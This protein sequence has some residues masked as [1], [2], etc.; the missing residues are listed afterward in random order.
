MNV[1]FFVFITT[2]IQ[3]NIFI[4]THSLYF[5]CCEYLE[6]PTR[7]KGIFFSNDFGENWVQKNNEITDTTI[8][9]LIVYQGNLVAGTNSRGVFI[10]M[11]NGNS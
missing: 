8:N 5:Y 4:Y 6:P 3:Y 10:S 9:S 11:D 2:P 7:H 1:I